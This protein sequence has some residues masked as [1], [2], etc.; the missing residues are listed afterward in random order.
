MFGGKLT[1][2]LSLDIAIEFARDS[3]SDVIAIGEDVFCGWSVCKSGW[4]VNVA[5]DRVDDSQ[6]KK[7][8]YVGERHE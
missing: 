1:R 3:D 2:G 6:L 5:I 4:L 7:H 8:K